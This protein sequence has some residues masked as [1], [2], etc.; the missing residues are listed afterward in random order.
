MSTSILVAQSPAAKTNKA[1]EQVPAATE[2]QL[3]PLPIMVSGG[4]TVM[5]IGLIIYGKIQTKKL[6][7]KLR[8]EK[9]PHPRVREEAEAISP[10]DS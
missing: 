1:S 5:V 2:T 7:K 10:N 9:I 8:F 4:L 3:P 6:E